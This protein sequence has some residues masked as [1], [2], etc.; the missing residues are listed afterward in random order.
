[1]ALRS[2]VLRRSFSSQCFLNTSGLIN[3][4]LTE[5]SHIEQYQLKL[6]QLQLKQQL[7]E[8]EKIWLNPEF[9]KLEKGQLQLKQGLA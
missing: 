7:H 4:G 9:L 1:M 5:F 2:S 8:P 6:E 3:H